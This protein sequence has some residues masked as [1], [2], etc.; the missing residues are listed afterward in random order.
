VSLLLADLNDLRTGVTN[1]AVV[2]ID[3]VGEGGGFVS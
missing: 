3:K 2:P 1:V